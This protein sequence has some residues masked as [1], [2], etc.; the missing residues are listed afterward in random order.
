M[1][2][3]APVLW[4]SRHPQVRAAAHFSASHFLETQRGCLNRFGIGLGLLD[5]G[6]ERTFQVFRQIGKY[7]LPEHS[8]DPDFYLL[9]GHRQR[10]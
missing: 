8:T 5:A 10:L 4:E 2:C 1:I 3:A 9:V 7:C 6:Y